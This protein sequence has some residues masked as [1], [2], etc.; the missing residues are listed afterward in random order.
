MLRPYHV[1]TLFNGLLDVMLVLWRH[2]RA[3]QTC[4]DPKA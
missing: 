4:R 3:L 2:H 1:F